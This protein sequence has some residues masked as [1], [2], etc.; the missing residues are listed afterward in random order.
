M[1]GKV[2]KGFSI[3]RKIEDSKVDSRDSPDVPVTIS[4][5]GQILPGD[6][7]EGMTNDPED[8]FEDY[9]GLMDDEMKPEMLLEI[10]A[11]L[12]ELGN[13]AFAAQNYDRAIEKYTKANPRPPSQT[14]PVP[15]TDCRD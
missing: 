15:A 9:P 14:F 6:S 12:K 7:E 2:L 8:P 4:D 1:F 13:A 3:V 5:C 11:K 10:A